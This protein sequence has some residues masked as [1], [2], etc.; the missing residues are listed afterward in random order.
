MPFSR[1]TVDRLERLE[2]RGVVALRLA[3]PV[4]DAPVGARTRAAAAI[5]VAARSMSDAPPWTFRFFRLIARSIAARSSAAGCTTSSTQTGAQRAARVASA[6]VQDQIE[7]ARETDEPCQPLRATGRRA[8]VRAMTSGRPT[9]TL[10][11]SAAMRQSHASASSSPPPSALPLI[12]ATVGKG[13][14]GEL[15]ADRLESSRLALVDVGGGWP[16]S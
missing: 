6:R 7:R 3:R 10:G 4:R 11:A 14:A 2:R 9:R 1:P 13:S 5:H 12:A 15:V 16:A 8:E